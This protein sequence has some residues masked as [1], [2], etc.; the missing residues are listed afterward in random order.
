[1]TTFN[2]TPA[3]YVPG[4]GQLY[5]TLDTTLTR[6]R[7]TLSQSRAQNP[8]ERRRNIRGAFAVTGGGEHLQGKTVLLI[9]DV[10]TTAATIIE[11]AHAL[12][13]AGVTRVDGFACALA[14]RKG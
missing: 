3:D 10:V 1:M 8:A 5:A 14:K 2:E 6:I 9:D 13:K 4:D 7:P 11:C 12:K